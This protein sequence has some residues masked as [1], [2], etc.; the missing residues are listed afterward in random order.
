[1]ARIRKVQYASHVQ[2]A[3]IPC[4]NTYKSKKKYSEVLVQKKNVATRG[5]RHFVGEVKPKSLLH[6]G[7]DSD[8]IGRKLGDARVGHEAQQVEDKVRALAKPI[9]RLERVAAGRAGRVRP[10]TELEVTYRGSTAR[11]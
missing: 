2:V 5:T 8:G 10:E 9:V 11:L 3:R 4:V 7:E 6:L 1:M